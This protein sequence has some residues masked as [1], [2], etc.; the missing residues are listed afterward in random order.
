M[1][2]ILVTGADGFVGRAL[3]HKLTTDGHDVVAAVRAVRQPLP[4]GTPI[5]VGDIGADI[6]WA[7]AL[8]GIQA[9]VHLAARVHVM[10]DEAAD[11]LA[12]FR[13]ANVVAT[14]R[15]AEQAATHGV[16]RFIFVSTAKV[17]GDVSTQPF[18]ETDA[19]S[20][21]DPYAVSKWEA[22]QSLSASAQRRGLGLVIL[23]PPLV[24]G[25]GVRANFWSL[26][27][28]CDTPWPLPLGG[29]DNRRSLLSL[30]NLA[31]AIAIALA[32]PGLVGRTWLLSDGH[33]ISTSELVARL[34]RALG[35]PARL[36]PAPRALIRA[37][38][39][40]GG[41]GAAVER[42]L[43]SLAV[44]SG[45]FR[46]ATGWEPPFDFESGLAATAAW[47]RNNRNAT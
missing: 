17:H 23:R 21:T 15:L 25:P 31:S 36:L 38:S 4:A 16:G 39:R 24:Y 29:I 11:K 3:C 5:V 45:A 8:A 2:R 27:R 43:G 1:A 22:E 34:R 14:Q 47:Y 7:P 33:D 26:L 13:R 10:R 41:R 35:R 9:V 18:R 42:V 6:D 32:A 44:D 19:P 46:A 40:L 37:I 20:P 28:L 12:A 30:G